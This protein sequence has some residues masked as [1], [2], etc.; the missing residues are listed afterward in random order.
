[1]KSRLQKK[2]VCKHTVLFFN[3]NTQQNGQNSTPLFGKENP[4]NMMSNVHVVTWRFP[5]Y[6]HS[7]PCLKPPPPQPPSPHGEIKR[8]PNVGVASVAVK[9]VLWDGGSFSTP[10][11]T[12]LSSKQVQWRHF[13]LVSISFSMAG[14]DCLIPGV[15]R[16]FLP[17]RQWRRLL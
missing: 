12:A 13:P 3:G 16:P 1:M 14:R 9:G 2:F 17:V 10:F 11:I 6:P 8:R 4:A 15:R 5:C 7:F